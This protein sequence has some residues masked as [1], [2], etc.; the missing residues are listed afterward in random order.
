MGVGVG[1][2]RARVQ[3]WRSRPYTGCVKQHLLGIALV[4]ACGKSEQK[5]AP[6][7]GEKGSAAS[8]QKSGSAAVVAADAATVGGAAAGI[9]GKANGVAF[10][11]TSAIARMDEGE[12]SIELAN[13]PQDCSGS[14]SRP[15]ANTDVDARLRI[16]PVLHE[17]GSLGWGVRGQYAHYMKPGETSTQNVQSEL[18]DGGT[19][20]SFDGAAISAAGAKTQIPID[21]SAGSDSAVTAKGSMTVLG[22][23]V[24]LPAPKP[25]PQLGDG[26]MTIA[27]KALPIAGAAFA[28]KKDGTHTLQL[29][30]QVVKCV[31]G[32]DSSTTRSDVYVTLTWDKAGKLVDVTR[33]G[34]WLSFAQSSELALTATPNRPSGAK[35]KTSLG[36]TARSAGY[37]IALAGKVD[38]IVCK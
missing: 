1:K 22:C 26:V 35:M 10:T 14:S 20:A 12:V 31:E 3:R 37:T 21:L 15:S 32:S 18:E 27:G 17:D 25:D 6:V 19:P 9:P 11:F 13:Y 36:G 16:G 33:G 2:V 29:G 23:G 7:A 5:S 30:T 28:I 34:H 24:K 4:V 8:E 38:A